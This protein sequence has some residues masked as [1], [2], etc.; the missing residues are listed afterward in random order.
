LTGVVGLIVGAS[1]G[2]GG[3]SASPSPAAAAAAAAAVRPSV[4][5]SV[6][7]VTDYL[8]IDA[9]PPAATVPAAAAPPVTTTPVAPPLVTTT[10]AAA[11]PGFGPGTYEVG[12]GEWKMPAGKYRT[13]G[14]SDSN[15]YWAREKNTSGEFSALIANGNTQGTAT[16]TIAK[17]DGAFE[18]NGCN[19][20][21]KIG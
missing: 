14:P 10:L 20:W 9:A 16:V 4:S 15:C 1:A 5:V 13:T 7:T 6:S 3:A 12:T 2:H 21:V 18:T 11:A 17:S 19:N 8:T